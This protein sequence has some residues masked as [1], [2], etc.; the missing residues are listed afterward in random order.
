MLAAMRSIHL[1]ARRYKAVLQRLVTG[2]RVDAPR[3]LKG[4]APTRFY[5][6]DGLSCPEC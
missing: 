4:L 1:E 3:S 6:K 5:D 2:N